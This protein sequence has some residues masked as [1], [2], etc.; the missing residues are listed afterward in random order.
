[1][2]QMCSSGDRIARVCEHGGVRP[3]RLVYVENDAALRGIMSRYLG[4]DEG[5]ELILSVSSPDE[6]LEGDHIERAD[7][8]LLDLALGADE[9]NGIDLGLA[10]RERNPDIGVVVYSQYSLQNMA[11]RVPESHLMGWSFIPKSGE[12]EIDELVSVIRT[13]AAGMSHDLA[14]SDDTV[15]DSG[16]LAKL[17]TRQ[18]AIMALAS[19]GLSSPEISRRLGLTYDAVRKDLSRAY[20]ILVPHDTTGDLRTKAV[21]SYLHLMRDKSWNEPSK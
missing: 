10:M 13:T 11:R 20:R 7:A 2:S 8:A 1:M 21:L 14:G 16:V 18:R 9:I 15:S 6:A 17:T 4:A 5:I 12:L 19:T 3:T